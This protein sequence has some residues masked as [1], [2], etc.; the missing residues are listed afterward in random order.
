MSD[1]AIV[2]VVT[3]A[4]VVAL[5][6]V[7]A[8]SLMITAGR[9]SR[10]EAA[11]LLQMPVPQAA[12]DTEEE[13]PKATVASTDRRR[14]PAQVLSLTDQ[15][16]RSGFLTG[17]VVIDALIDSGTFFEL[18][19]SWSM[20]DDANV[21]GL[22]IRFG[23]SD[24]HLLIRKQDVPTAAWDALLLVLTHDDHSEADRQSLTVVAWQDPDDAWHE[25]NE[26]AFIEAAE[27]L[28]EERP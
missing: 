13:K 9:T 24:T 21:Q 11:G 20:I 16:L 10:M 4:I 25:T 17:G 15:G 6:G 7:L 22:V 28:L 12:L 14:N 8:I 26:A 19:H 18:P 27:T 3:A 2:T 5:F 23:T 1:I